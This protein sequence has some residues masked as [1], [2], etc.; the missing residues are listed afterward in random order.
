MLIDDI[1]R[2][3]TLRRSLGFKLERAAEYLGSFARFAAARGERHIRTQTAIE[4]AQTAPTSGSRYTRL[5]DVVRAARFLFLS[6][7]GR[8][9]SYP[10]AN[11]AFREIVRHADIA[12]GRLQRPRIHDLRH[13]FATRVL[14]QCGAGRATIARHAVA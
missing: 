12:P 4:W 13:T 3:L 11:K 14:E 1:E 9:L 6:V 8:R 2:Y 7:R 10:V 5:R